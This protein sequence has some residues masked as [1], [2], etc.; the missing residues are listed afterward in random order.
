[1]LENI[2]VMWPAL[3]LAL[4]GVLLPLLFSIQNLYWPMLLM[5]A[6]SWTAL[7][8]KK[9]KKLN[10][11][12]PEIDKS[13]KQLA[14]SIDS[15]LGELE[16]CSTQEIESLHN[17]L[18]QLKSVVSDAV[19]TMSESFNG[20][21]KLAIDQSSLV[22]SMMSDFDGAEDNGNDRKMTFQH[23]ATETDKVLGFFIDYV[24]AVSKQSM[25]MVSVVNDVGEH[26]YKIEKLVTDVQGIA[27][28]TNLLA[29][30][31]A[32]EAA[33]AGEAGRGFAVV[34]D[35]VRNLSKN[36]DKFSEEIRAVVNDS[37]N[38][39]EQAQKMIEAMASKDMSIAISSKSSVDEMMQEISYLNDMSEQKLAEVSTL[40]NHIEMNVANAVRALQFEDMSRQ[41]VE[42][43]QSKIQRF[44]AL[45]DEIRVGLGFLKTGNAVNWNYEFEQGKGRLQAMK[46]QWKKNEQKTVAQESMEEGEI[47][48]F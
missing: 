31:A 44:Q 14:Q 17:E 47:E 42:H 15:Y 46:Q 19:M 25:E 39:I 1:M 40:G 28:Q 29:L 35:E 24:L 6:I 20:V 26:M 36:S 22:V 3:F 33:R 27:D 21:N 16:S 2:K 10:Q 7:A 13:S 11:Y 9:E 34:A 45:T 30:N 48:L 43:M 23:F 4:L 38:N 12:D 41:L 18:K 5:F 32:I 37:K 8:L